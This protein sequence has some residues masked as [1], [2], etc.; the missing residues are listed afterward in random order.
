VPPVGEALNPTRRT[1]SVSSSKISG[2][3]AAAAPRIDR[4]QWQ[5]CT[6]AARAQ[7]D[8]SSACEGVQLPPGR[9]Y[10]YFSQPVLS[11]IAS[12]KIASYQDTCFPQM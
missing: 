2:P 7:T 5:E 9:G 6:A 11:L 4:G 12:K 1:L 8:D 3:I 10:W